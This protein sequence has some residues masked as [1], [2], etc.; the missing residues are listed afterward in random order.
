MGKSS[1]KF[2]DMSFKRRSTLRQ[3]AVSQS[4]EITVTAMICLPD[5]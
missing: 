2:S 1:A 5:C 3:P 4:Y